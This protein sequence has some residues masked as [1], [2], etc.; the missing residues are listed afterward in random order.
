MILGPEHGELANGPEHAEELQNAGYTRCYHERQPG[1][2]CNFHISPEA[3]QSALNQDSG[4][5]T[6]P[7]CK[8]SGDLNQDLPWHGTSPEEQEYNYQKLQEERY[9]PHVHYERT[10][11]PQNF[12]PGG[13][14]R[15]GIP[16][17]QQAQVGE[18]LVEQM[19]SLP[20]YGPILWWHPGGATSASPL[21]GATKE[22]G[23]EVKTLGYDDIHHRFIPGSQKERSDKNDEATQLGLKG[24]L[25]VM[26][27]LNYRTSL[28]DIYV[29]EMP[30]EP[31]SNAQGRVL[32]G[33]AT[34]RS[35]VATHLVAQV[36]FKNPLLNP[37]DA[38]P[39]TNEDIPF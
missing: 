4:Y 31:W 14:T 34:F 19:K 25:G 13:I 20:G 27:L 12:T 24:I 15:I 5:Y 33:V 7:R 28:A 21:D 29:K 11:E 22:W 3:Q 30:L 8:R 37:H 35:G 1:V 16:L 32:Q 10:G 38:T 6:C 23:I 39:V 9:E 18:D 17:Q 2:P 26:V 36:P